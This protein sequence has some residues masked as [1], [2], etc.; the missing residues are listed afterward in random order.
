MNIHI[1][2]MPRSGSKTVMQYMTLYYREKY[3]N[4]FVSTLISTKDI[5]WQGLKSAWSVDE[6]L[7]HHH[8]GMFQG[9]AE[10]LNRFEILVSDKKIDSIEKE[11]ISRLD[12]IQNLTEPYILKH[13]PRGYTHITDQLISIP[14]NIYYI[15]RDDIFNHTLSWALSQRL[16][17]WV[18]NNHQKNMI[19]L[20]ENSP[21]TV[22]H[23]AFRGLLRELLHFSKKFNDGR[24]VIRFEDIIALNNARDFCTLFNLDF[25]DFEFV[26]I[27]EEF[28]NHKLQMIANINELHDIYTEEIEE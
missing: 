24:P 10:I 21:I 19:S 23:I 7:N 8:K 6:F 22:D 20:S 5:I 14:A 2:T 11:L 9:H 13:F 26:K 12:I 18:N 4:L 17:S 25:V 28:G 27:G 15:T 1:I 16:A 3:K